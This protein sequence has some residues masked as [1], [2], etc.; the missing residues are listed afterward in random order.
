MPRANVAGMTLRD[1]CHF[2]ESG[3]TAADCETSHISRFV[4][5]VSGLASGLALAD[6]PAGLAEALGSRVCPC[7]ARDAIAG[8]AL[9]AGGADPDNAR[10]GSPI[11]VTFQRRTAYL[12]RDDRPA[13]RALR[14]PG[15]NGPM[16]VLSTRRASRRVA[17]RTRYGGCRYLPSWSACCGSTSSRMGLPLMGACSGLTAAAFTSRRLSG[18]CCGRPG[19]GVSSCYRRLAAGP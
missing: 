15:G 18:R 11:P 12:V 1:R 8:S 2:Y 7:V 9:D 6:R 19:D 3:L 10:Q 14:E 17:R 13:G 4:A 16:T 5:R